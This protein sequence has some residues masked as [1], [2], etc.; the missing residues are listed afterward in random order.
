MDGYPYFPLKT[1][2]RG[3]DTLVANPVSGKSWALNRDGSALAALC[4]GRRSLDDIIERVSF[5]TGMDADL[6]RPRTEAAL[7]VLTAQGMLWWRRS[8]ERWSPAPRPRLFY[9]DITLKC[10]LHCAHCVV[11][12]GESLPSEL[13]TAECLGVLDQVAAYGAS[14]VVFSGG[15][16]LMRPDVLQLAARAHDLGMSAQM[17]T[18]GTLVTSALARAIA[19]LG[20]DVQVSVDGPNAEI[21]DRFRGRPGAFDLTLAGI[22]RL[23]EEGASFMIGTV[24]HRGNLAEIRLMYELA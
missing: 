7:A 12:A 21:H 24:L 9:W 3:P 17:A 18:N 19:D 1:D 20:I 8:K 11:R 13:S 4:D 22:A 15:E 23:R 5:E 10:N 16:P 2:R 6:V 14:G